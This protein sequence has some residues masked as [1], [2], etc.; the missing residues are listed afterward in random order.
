DADSNR[1]ATRV[2]WFGDRRHVGR[3]SGAD[4]LCATAD[5]RS[6]DYAP[7]R[8]IASPANSEKTAI[9]KTTASS[10]A[11][12]RL[13]SQPCGPSNAVTSLEADGVDR[14]FKWAPTRISLQAARAPFATP[15]RSSCQMTK[16]K[17]ET[18]IEMAESPPRPAWSCCARSARVATVAA[19]PM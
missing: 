4:V 11:N 7:A 5:S 13:G 12:G 1:R 15:N 14:S 9:T 18:A 10:P 3:C 6:D 8:Q 2:L 19:E 16:K 17:A